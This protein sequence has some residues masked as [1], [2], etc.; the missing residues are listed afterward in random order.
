MKRK[1]MKPLRA[2]APAAQTE[3]G[4]GLMP[5]IRRALRIVLAAGAPAA[6]SLALV[7]GMSQCGLA[8]NVWYDVSGAPD[9]LWTTAAGWR[10]SGGALGRLPG[11]DDNVSLDGIQTGPDNPIVIP[12]GCDAVMKNLWI[13]SISGDANNYAADGRIPSLT[14]YGTL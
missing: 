10:Y 3:S 9:R 8:A 6:K 14:L 13:S 1:N 11:Q 7:L 5:R 4:G 2:A 12:A